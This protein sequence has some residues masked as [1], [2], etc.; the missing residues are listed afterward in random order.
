MFVAVVHASA[1]LAGD[2]YVRALTPLV[3]VAGLAMTNRI[4]FQSFYINAH[5]LTGEWLAVLVGVTWLAVARRIVLTPAL[6]V[7]AGLA[8]AGIVLSRPEGVLLVFVV[9]APMLA[10]V[11]EHAC[12]V[13]RFDSLNRMW[14]HWLLIATI[15]V[16]VSIVAGSWRGKRPFRFRRTASTAA[17]NGTS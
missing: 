7:A 13:G 8:G 6:A 3:V 9:L 1:N 16:G 10:Y 14:V 12:R 11:R 2:Y 5:M 4:V 15:S 17:D